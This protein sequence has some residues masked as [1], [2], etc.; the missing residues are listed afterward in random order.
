[1]E[2]SIRKAIIPAAGLG[3]RLLPATKSHP[4]EML[5][6]GRKPVVHH[7]VEELQA[8]DLRQILIIT[9]RRKRSIEDHFDADPQLMA[10][11]EEAGNERLLDDLAYLEGESRF[12]FT[13]QS[14][15]KGLGHAVLLA[16]DFV[17]DDDCVVALGDSI[18][19]GGDPA[20]LLRR[21]M[22]LH[23][24]LDAAAVIAV[25]QVPPDET[26]RYGIVAIDEDEPVPGQPLLM[27]DVV[28]K[29]PRGVAPSN[30]AIA[31]RY[32]FAPSI[33]SALE[34]T[35]PDRRGE[36]QL[37]DAIR[38][39]LRAGEPVY[40]LMLSPEQKRYDVGNFESYFQTFIDFALADE[41]YGY[42]VRKYIKSIAYDL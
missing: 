7:V 36:L 41:R 38:L 4:K 35:L 27:T 19:G 1:M 31:A 15:P 37:T 18:I 32:V 40:A 5:P 30:L 11:L 26:F 8:A 2:H 12:F 16:K 13:R 28:E 3:T 34:R 33:F 9:G 23:R 39:L 24:E 21:M 10:V 25:E 22:A 17:G 14:S 42:L 20:A 29:P 6:V